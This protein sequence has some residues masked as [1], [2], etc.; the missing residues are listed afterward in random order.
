MSRKRNSRPRRWSRATGD[1]LAALDV[2]EEL[3][4]SYKVPED[5]DEG[6]TPEEAEEELTNARQAL[7]ELVSLQEEY[8]EWNYNLPE[9]L[10]SSHLGEKLEAIAYL[11]LQ[12][13]LDAL[14]DNFSDMDLGHIRY[15]AEEADSADLPLGF[16]RD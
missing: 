8:E 2:L 7:E 5:G 16:G 14:D 13:A 9:G 12:G 4:E 15:V 3:Q 1:A 11:D 10:Q 6:N